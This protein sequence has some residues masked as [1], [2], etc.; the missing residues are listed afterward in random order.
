MR[1]FRIIAAGVAAA[2]LLTICP[3]ALSQNL[4]PIV[5]DKQVQTVQNIPIWG[6]I[7]Q[8]DPN[9]DPVILSVVKEAEKG[10]VILYGATF[11]YR[12][13]TDEMGAD[14][15]T[16]TAADDKQTHSR[17]A[18]I[19]VEIGEN[20]QGEGF[21]DMRLNPSHY[22]ALMLAQNKIVSG[23]SIG[24]TRLFRPNEEISRTGFMLML[25]AASGS[26][27]ELAP[28]VS[29]D[30]SNDSDIALW[31]K[32]YVHRA[33]QKGLIDAGEFLGDESILRSEAIELVCRA[34]GIEDV[35]AQPVHILD[36]ADIPADC[37]QSYLNLSARD[38]L[39]LYDG[40]AR[41]LAPLTRAAAADL[42]WQLCR[43][44]QANDAL[45]SQR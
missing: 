19:T 33:R 17:D 26:D 35:R 29:V 30:V 2:A 1:F 39:C 12:P 10:M 22:S 9:G 24:G 18:Q 14:S 38:M 43:Y 42:V 31:L 34:A 15:F 5:N 37:L 6:Y 45:V 4:P 40:Y 23:E 7:E 16:V 20:K 36:V 21:S 44:R 8:Y 11:V 32:P 41:P 27:T 3:Y 25:L 28:C 13:Y